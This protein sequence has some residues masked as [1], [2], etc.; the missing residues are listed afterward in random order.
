MPDQPIFLAI[1]AFDRS[2][3][4]NYMENGF[5]L[6]H[7][8]SYLSPVYE[9]YFSLLKLAYYKVINLKVIPIGYLC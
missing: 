6:D 9:I 8:N 4:E 5:E 1:L 7:N 2:I 3:E